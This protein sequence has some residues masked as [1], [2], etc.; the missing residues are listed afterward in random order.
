MKNCLLRVKIW[1]NCN[2][3]FE[4]V[5]SWTTSFIHSTWYFRYYKKKSF[6]KVKTKYS[7][8]NG[9]IA[10]QLSVNSLKTYSPVFPRSILF[11][12]VQTSI[13]SFKRKF[14]VACP[15][16]IN[17]R[18]VN[19]QCIIKVRSFYCEPFL[20]WQHSQWP[21]TLLSS[22]LICKKVSWIENISFLFGK[23]TYNDTAIEN[24]YTHNMIIK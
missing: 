15:F 11:Y 3:R 18:L 14:Y 4:L 6:Y 12:F 7:Y 10:F 21:Q 20:G 2:S 24:S 23:T 16:S 22:K 13:Q 9:N 19:T 8:R 5:G 1:I 17:H